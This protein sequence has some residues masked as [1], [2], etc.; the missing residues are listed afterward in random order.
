MHRRSVIKKE[1]SEE[2]AEKHTEIIDA[3]PVS[4]K[5]DLKAVPFLWKEDHMRFQ[6][7]AGSCIS[8]SSTHYTLFILDTSAF[9]RHEDFR[10]MTNA[11]GNISHYFCRPTHVA[12]MTFSDRLHLELCFN[13]HDSTTNDR[14]QLSQNIKNIPYRGGSTS[15]Y[16]GAAAKCACSQMLHESCGFPATTNS[17][18][19]VFVTGAHSNDPKH[20]IC[21]EVKCLHE[22]STNT[23]AIG[24]GNIN[25]TELNC[26]ANTTVDNYFNIFNFRSFVEF[27]NAL[28]EAIF[29]IN[30]LDY[31]HGNS[32]FL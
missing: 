14:Y 27:E 28:A 15:T 11:I 20:R 9:L 32:T 3:V 29:I 12:V 24:I 2:V 1:Y 8:S 30:T 31:L 17:I 7:M 10:R 23:F 16:I 5:F 26:M 25:Q 18:D 13:C 22:K 4:A 19:I 21:N 6:R